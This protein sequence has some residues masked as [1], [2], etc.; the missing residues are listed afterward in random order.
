MS[1]QTT[2]LILLFVVFVIAFAGLMAAASGWRT[3]AQRFPHV[4]QAQGQRYRLASAKMGRVPWFPVNFGATLVVTVGPTGFSMSAYFPFRFFCPAF[5][6][7]WS[8]VESVKER[9]TALSR[10]T[11]V[12]FRDSSVQLALR[13]AV[14]QSVF[15]MYTSMKDAKT[16]APSTP[17]AS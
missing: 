14:A 11:V 1:L 4:M 8:E 13:G 16:L 12:R 5:F 2:F 3:L 6:V 17:A 7:P 9:S 15:V 10:R